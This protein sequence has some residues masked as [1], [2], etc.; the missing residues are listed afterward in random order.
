MVHVAR[1]PHVGA[2][3]E[4]TQ[5]RAPV[6]LGP[7][8]GEQVVVL[9]LLE[10]R[11]PE[12]LVEPV[13]HQAALDAAW[14]PG[15]ALDALPPRQRGVPVVDDVVVVEDHE[16]RHAGE[17]PAH[18]AVL[19]GFLVQPR[20]LLEA[21]DLGP[22]SAGRTAAPALQ[23][24]DG[25]R[26]GLVG[27]HLVADQQQGVRTGAAG[28]HPPGDPQQRMRPEAPLVLVGQARPRRAM[29]SPLLAGAHHEPEPPVAGQGPDRRWRQPV[30]QGPG[31]LP[32]EVTS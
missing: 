24:G 3:G 4:G 22:A 18:Q 15:L 30:G 1:R 31:A 7:H 5:C 21:G 27:V 32:V 9:A 6:R 8:L 17:K 29:G 28:G 10:R 2:P 14:P 26:V 23:C 12:V 13:R 19:P 16:R 20:V 11:I 25:R